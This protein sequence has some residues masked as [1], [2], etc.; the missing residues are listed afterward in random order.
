MVRTLKVELD[1]RSYP[2]Y[3]AD[4]LLQDPKV[5]AHHLRSNQ[6]LIVS[7]ETVAE[8]YLDRVKQAFKQQQCDVVLLPD[9]EQYKNLTT[10]SKIFDALLNNRHRRN[11]TL[12][13]LGGG[14]IC[15]MTGFAA[16]CYQRGV[17]FIQIPTTL[18]AQVDASIGGK[19][20]VNHP[21]GKNM[22]GAFHQPQA[23]VIDTSVLKTLSNREFSAGMAEI[24][25]AALIQ[26]K[27]FF[28]W[29]EKNIDKLMQREPDTLATAIERACA[30]KATIV[31]ADEH[32][33]TGQRALLNL[34]HTFG[35]AIEQVL[36]YGNWLHGEAV[37][38]GI[39]LAAEVSQLQ[40]WIKTE[41]VERIKKL[42]LAAQLPIRL[43]P[44]IQYDKMTAA[45][46]VDKK[47]QNAALKLVLLKAIGKAELISD[48]DT[49]QVRQVLENK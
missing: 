46:A 45:M 48:V 36:G 24:I 41:D 10:L 27:D 5:W 40:G 1:T 38:T 28:N 2:I 32:E 4:N 30:I 21:L 26:D 8:L 20:A 18:L 37:A 9:G 29:L 44:Q 33:I 47:L 13:A 34:G 6:V 25:K 16:A 43:P 3:I 7:N 15:D 49:R 11:T 14:V 23:V 39:V 17:A 19:T 42:F 12:I 22:I 35:H 31:A